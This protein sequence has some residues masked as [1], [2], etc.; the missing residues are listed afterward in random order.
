MVSAPLRSSVPM[1]SGGA[2]RSYAHYGHATMPGA[3]SGAGYRLHTISSASVHSIGGGRSAGGGGSMGGGSS[4]SRGVSYGGVSY[5][6]PTLALATPSYASDISESTQLNRAMRKVKE[7]GD[8]SYNGEYYN[9]QWWNED[10]EDWFDEPFDGAIK[11]EDG[12]M[13]KYDAETHDWKLVSGQADPTPLG[14]TPWH[15]MLLLALGYYMA[16]KRGISSCLK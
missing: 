2:V 3:T 6:M 10:E 9:G 15:W 4:T 12:L 16:K 5:S 8:G 7:N 11:Y 14:D 13:Y 1:V